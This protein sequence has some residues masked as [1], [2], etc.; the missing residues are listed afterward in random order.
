MPHDLIILIIG[1][2]YGVIAH[3]VAEEYGAR[4]RGCAAVLAGALWPAVFVGIA[5]AWAAR[6]LSR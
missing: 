1:I 5:A 2:C 3:T 6:R 4:G